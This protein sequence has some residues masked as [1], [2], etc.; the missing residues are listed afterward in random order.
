[1]KTKWEKTTRPSK[2]WTTIHRRDIWDEFFAWLYQHRLIVC[3]G[4]WPWGVMNDLD[5]K[6][7]ESITTCV[8]WANQSC[9][10][11]SAHAATP[12]SSINLISCLPG[13][14]SACLNLALNKSLIVVYA[15]FF[16]GRPFPPYALDLNKWIPI[17]RRKAFLLRKKEHCWALNS[18]VIAT[19][20]LT[21][22]CRELWWK[23]A[24]MSFW[25]CK[26]FFG[27]IHFARFSLRF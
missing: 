9:I 13:L 21:K 20:L 10:S 18:V 25:S 1:M 23:S 16:A 3:Y 14:V 26:I 22:H 11:L 15:T 4:S 2:T 6:V 7:K 12:A 17:Q 19:C 8:V 5:A 24:R 27:E